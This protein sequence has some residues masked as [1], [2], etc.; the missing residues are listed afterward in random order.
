MHKEERDS[1]YPEEEEEEEEDNR[2]LFICI[3][4]QTVS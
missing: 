2:S 4:L 1:L 3:C